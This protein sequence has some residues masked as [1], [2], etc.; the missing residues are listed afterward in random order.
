MKHNVFIVDDHDVTRRGYAALINADPT[1]EVCGEA[2][3]AGQ[4]LKQVTETAPDLVIVDIS[5]P[6]MSGI[7]LIKHLEALLPDLRILVV[8]MHDE[9]LYA[10]RVL[11]AGADGYV[12][13]SEAHTAIVKALR[14]VA[15][16]SIYLS[17]RMNRKLLEQYMNRSTK[18]ETSPLEQLTDRELETFELIGR[19][20]STSQIADAMCISPKTVGT[21]RRRIKSKLA[22]ATSAELVQ[23]AVQWI[24]NEASAPH[25]PH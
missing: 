8:S 3:A 24:Q 21:Y 7:E 18:E 19:G 22:L 23:H 2:S 5:L 25:A 1:F 14:Q 17:D 11:R 15:G 12:M 10:E 20:L 4:A 6:D 13:K 16:G 9:K